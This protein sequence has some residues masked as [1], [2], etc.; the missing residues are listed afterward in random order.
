MCV[1]FMFMCFRFASSID[2]KHWLA[3][4]AN[5]GKKI[6]AVYLRSKALS[7]WP[8]F[9][10]KENILTNIIMEEIYFIRVTWPIQAWQIN[11]MLHIYFR[12]ILD[13]LQ[14]FRSCLCWCRYRDNHTFTIYCA[15]LHALCLYIGMMLLQSLPSTLTCDSSKII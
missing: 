10:I 9:L 8:N 3:E 1:V 11:W 6:S 13:L 15:A 14:V 7:D 4:D 2:S 12:W 5:T